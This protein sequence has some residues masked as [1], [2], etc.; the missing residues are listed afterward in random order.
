[1]A[2]DMDTGGS[3]VS[4]DAA[5]SDEVDAAEPVDYEAFYTS[6]IEHAQRKVAKAEEN[7]RQAQEGVQVAQR[8]LDEW[9]AAE[10]E[11]MA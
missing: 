9:R 3:A 11:A 2:D 8:N 1:M 4:H 6:R 5:A 7:L 10:Q